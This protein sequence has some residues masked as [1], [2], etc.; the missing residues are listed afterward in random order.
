MHICN[1]NGRV[2]N[3][4]LRTKKAFRKRLYLKCIETCMLGQVIV[5]ICLLI[6]A[7]NYLIFF[8]LSLSCSFILS[9]DKNSLRKLG[10]M[11]TSGSR[12]VS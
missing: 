6:R 2:L 9:G 1:H 5:S 12:A 10:K 7:L 3:T 11:S 4:F 8:S